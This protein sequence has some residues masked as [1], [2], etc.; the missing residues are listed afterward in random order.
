MKTTGFK[1]MEAWAIVLSLIF[2]LALTT[3]EAQQKFKIAGTGE[4]T[5]Y[6]NVDGK[7]FNID[8]AEGHTVSLNKYEANNI[9]TGET[10][11]MHN[12]RTVNIALNDITKGNGSHHG[13]W[14]F[15][16]GSDRIVLQYEGK[17]TNTLSEEGNP[18][19]KINGK[20]RWVNAT[21]K[22]ENMHGVVTYK[23]WS[24]PQNNF[25]V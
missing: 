8:D 5:N 6:T 14:T 4:Y 1:K 25:T 7:S 15:E 13:Y 3:A 17:I 9:S 22:Y 24:T 2:T 19:T 21:G 20:A 12:A 18:V 10:E 16:K 23:G 11:W